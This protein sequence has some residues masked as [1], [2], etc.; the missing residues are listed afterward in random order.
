SEIDDELIHL[1][2]DESELKKLH[3]KFED[4]IE[5]SYNTDS[6]RISIEG[7]VYPNSK[8]RILKDILE[9]SEE[10]YSIEISVN[11]SGLEINEVDKL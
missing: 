10:K 4:E 7:K 9:I 6:L 11:D 1:M 3:S 8:I 5:K 2:E